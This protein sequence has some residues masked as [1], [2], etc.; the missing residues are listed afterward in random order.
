[1]PNGF[2]GSVAHSY[3]SLVAAADS[4]ARDAMRDI[5]KDVSGIGRP[6]TTGLSSA[7]RAQ[8]SSASR[9]ISNAARIP[10]LG[11]PKPFPFRVEDAHRGSHK[12]GVNNSSNIV[13]SVGEYNQAARQFTD[14]DDRMGECLY[15]TALEIEEMCNA[16]F[17]MP[18]VTPR[19]RHIAETVKAC[20]GQ[21]RE[22]SDN[23]A[24]L[25]RRFAQEID[26]LELGR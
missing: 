21:M 4:N 26:T 12:V 2:R 6:V 8:V 14:I 10:E 22:I 9:T 19:C 11:P 3:L 15:R 17:M 16:I 5:S 18:N 24:T 25:A 20:L 13:L 1:M 23:I 7:N